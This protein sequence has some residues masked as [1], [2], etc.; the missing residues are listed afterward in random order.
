MPGCG[1]ST[2]G[3]VLAKTSGKDFT[4]TDLLIQEHEGELLQNIIDHNGIEYFKKIEAKVLTELTKKNCVIATGGS[5]IYYPEAMNHLKSQGAVIYIKLSLETIKKRLDNMKTRGIAM[6]SGVTLEMLYKQ[7]IP[8]YE[9]YADIVIDGENKDV[10]EL[11]TMMLKELA[12]K[13]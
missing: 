2:V 10:E 4:D 11:V 5:A 6:E 13:R 1:K 8:L 3:V 7:R 9:E 12:T